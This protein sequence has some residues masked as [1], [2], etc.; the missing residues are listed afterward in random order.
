MTTPMPQQRL[1]LDPHDMLLE[2]VRAL[3]GPK[4]VGSW[5]RPELP[6]EQAAQWVRDCVNAQRREKFDPA[7]VFAMLK[8]ARQAG[9]HDAMAYLAGECGYR[10]EAVEPEDERARLQREFV[11]AVGRLEE[12]RASLSRNGAEVVAM[13]GA[14]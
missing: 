9:Y 1:I 5:L 3:G 2:L 12:I 8:R 11:D 6:V 14:R 7:H 10:V 13:K 4:E